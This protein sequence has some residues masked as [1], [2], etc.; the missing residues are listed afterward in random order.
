MP[1][2]LNQLTNLDIHA[3]VEKQQLVHDVQEAILANNYNI[4]ELDDKRPWGA[5]FRFD[6]DEADRFVEEF[7]PGLDGTE[8]RLGDDSLELSPKILL[9]SP[10]QRLSWQYHNHRA[11]RWSFLTPGFYYRSLT[12]TAGESRSANPSE[13]VQFA[14]KERHRLVGAV[15]AY[16]LVAEIWQHTDRNMPSTESDIVRV[17]DDYARN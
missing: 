4:V 9:A 15:A 13:V 10:D 8:A 1:E 7:F 2:L 16:T 11:E 14:K 12:D 3:N 17:Q 5:Y 6:S